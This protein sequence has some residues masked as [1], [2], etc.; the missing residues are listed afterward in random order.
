[1]AE[2]I[3][4]VGGNRAS[5]PIAQF[6]K[7]IDGSPAA[8]TALL[9][10]GLGGG[11]AYI[12]TDAG[13]KTLATGTAGAKKVLL[14]CTVTEVFA[15]GTGAQPTVKIGEVGSD[16]SLAATSVFTGATLNKV[17]VLVGNLT[18]ST[19]LIATVTAAT[20]TGTGGLSIAAFILPASI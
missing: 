14:I 5:R 11:G 1:M 16:A 4:T 2:R 12:K 9:A 17:F 6:L 18:A 3:L 19:N 15:N 8:V 13:V 10:A 7:T 20:L